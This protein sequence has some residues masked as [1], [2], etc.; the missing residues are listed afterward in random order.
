LQKN[1]EASKMVSWIEKIPSDSIGDAC[2]CMHPEKA[3]CKAGT[4]LE[5]HL[6]FSKAIASNYF[7]R[8]S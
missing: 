2:L 8:E 5:K 6:A 7:V 4:Y 3:S 1:D